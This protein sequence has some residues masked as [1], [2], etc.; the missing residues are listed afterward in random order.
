MTFEKATKAFVMLIVTS[1]FS[2]G[3]LDNPRT[4]RIEFSIE[5]Q[6]EFLHQATLKL[7]IFLKIRM[8]LLLAGEE[9]KVF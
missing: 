8:G 9:G 6:I 2:Q 1:R 4:K 3:T 7:S 5:T